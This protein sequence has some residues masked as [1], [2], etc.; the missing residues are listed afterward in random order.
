MIRFLLQDSYLILSKLSSTLFQSLT[1][2]LF[3][4]S[5]LSSLP[6]IPNYIYIKFHFLPPHLHISLHFPFT[7]TLLSINFF[8]FKYSHLTFLIALPLTFLTTSSSSFNSINFKVISFSHFFLLIHSFKISQLHYYYK[9]FL[10][11]FQLIF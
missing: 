9:I 10:P 11:N 7:L 5:I 6:L 8:I 3:T 4:S 2:T 1:I